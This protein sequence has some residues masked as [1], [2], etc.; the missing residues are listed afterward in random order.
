[1]Q[2]LLFCCLLPF[3]CNCTFIV[4]DVNVKSLDIS[5]DLPDQVL[6][7]EMNQLSD[8]SLSHLNGWHHFLSL[9][10]FNSKNVRSIL[11]D[12]D[13]FQFDSMEI[14]FSLSNQ[15][16]K[17][18]PSSS[19]LAEENNRK[20]IR[21]SLE[22]QLLRQSLMREELPRHEAKKSVSFWMILLY[23]LSVVSPVA[24]IYFLVNFRKSRK[25][26]E[27]EKRR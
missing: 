17:F 24:L 22:H 4:V 20:L 10:V 6:N 11:S 27:N 14:S 26:F 8:Q 21:A 15:I 13:S 3:V 18:C 16:Y 7:I 5:A 2:I 19:F 9:A 1:M 12:F 25:R 23:V